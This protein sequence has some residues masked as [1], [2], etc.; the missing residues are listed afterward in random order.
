MQE[1]ESGVLAFLGLRRVASGAGAARENVR[2][3]GRSAWLALEL[4][5]WKGKETT[6]GLLM[7]GAGVDMAASR[8]CSSS[9]SRQAGRRAGGLGSAV[10]IA[11]THSCSS[12]VAATA[13][14]GSE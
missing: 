8:K 2:G 9:S 5:G 12:T 3:G 7:T 1:R 4:A 13:A 10:G 6:T 14:S 11:S